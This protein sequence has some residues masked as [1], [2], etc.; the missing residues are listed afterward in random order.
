MHKGAELLL[1]NRVGADGR[2]V[3][4]VA[5][6]AALRL[7][8]GLGK[9]VELAADAVVAAVGLEVGAR[10]LVHRF[11]RCRELARARLEEGVGQGSRGVCVWRERGC[12]LQKDEEREMKKVRGREGKETKK[13][14]G[15]ADVPKERREGEGKKER[16]KK[17]R[18]MQ[19]YRGMRRGRT[20]QE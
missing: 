19:R 18:E 8:H 3:G 14:K 9:G 6:R 11:H 16:R 4:P 2:W 7:N 10:R 1:E 13:R 12:W 15:E 20:E 5:P 17:G